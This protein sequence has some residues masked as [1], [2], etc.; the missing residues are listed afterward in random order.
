M[1][2]NPRILQ[3][4]LFRAGF[5]VQTL[6]LPGRRCLSDYF[7]SLPV[8]IP[9]NA[10][11]SMCKPVGTVS[12]GHLVLHHLAMP[13]IATVTTWSKVRLQSITPCCAVSRAAHTTI[14]TMYRPKLQKRTAMVGVMT[15]VTIQ[16]TAG[17]Y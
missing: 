4:C 1:L 14:C 13:Q 7:E 3:G 10:Y 12:V 11:V 2:T 16:L 6:W 8:K 5:L 17:A 15:Q 9:C